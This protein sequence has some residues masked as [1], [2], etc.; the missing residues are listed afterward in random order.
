MP[1][2][3]T[4]Q[5]RDFNVTLSLSTIDTPK[6]GHMIVDVG[7]GD[8]GSREKKVGVSSGKYKYD[9]YR[10]EGE[11][12]HF[13]DNGDGTAN[14]L[15]PLPLDNVVAHV[16]SLGNVTLY[17]SGGIYPLDATDLEAAR[18]ARKDATIARMKAAGFTDADIAAV[19]ST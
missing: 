3:N 19:T 10:R 16:D 18:K 5:Y 11:S 1:R 4:V 8:M 2:K 9:G 12:V 6:E 13:V 15:T 14:L 7:Y 17:R